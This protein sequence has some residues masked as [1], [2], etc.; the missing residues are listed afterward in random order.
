MAETTFRV[1]QAMSPAAIAPG[2]DPP[3]E[4]KQWP[5]RTMRSKHHATV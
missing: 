4:S 2:N 5:S 3:M 1:W